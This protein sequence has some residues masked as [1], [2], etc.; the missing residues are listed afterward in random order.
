MHRPS[1]IQ[2]KTPG[3][4]WFLKHGK[5]SEVPFV[6]YGTEGYMFESCRVYWVFSDFK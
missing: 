6:V 1:L 3:K 4:P 5:S 2:S